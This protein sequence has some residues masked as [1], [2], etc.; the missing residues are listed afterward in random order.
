MKKLLSTTAM[1][2]PISVFA[3]TGTD[4][5]EELVVS[6]TRL[7]ETKSSVL[8][9]VDVVTSEE[10]KIRNLKNL[11]E[12][13]ALLPGVQTSTYGG[14]GQSSS[15]Y[16]RGGN[17]NQVLVLLDGET[18]STGKISNI[19]TNQIPANMIEKVEFIRGHRASVYG[20]N[21]VLGVINIITKP[22]YHTSQR[23]A[24]TY[25]SYATHDFLTQNTIAI[26]DK[27]VIKL[28]GGVGSSKGFNVHPVPGLNDGAEHGYKQHNLQL[29]YSHLFD[30]NLEV[31][32][33]YKYIYNKGDYD[34]SY[35][36]PEIDENEND[37]HLLSGGANYTD[38][39]Y[40][41]DF[42]VMYSHDNDYNYPENT[43]KYGP[44]S[45]A[46]KVKSVNSH[47][48]NEFTVAEPW[49]VGFGVDYD[50]S[51]LDKDSNSYGANFG[52][53]NISL[54]NRAAYLYTKVDNEFMLGELSGRLDDN[55][56][57]GN[58]GTYSIG[59]GGKLPLDSLL[60]VRYG[61]G[62]RAP[63][64]QEL[65]FPYYGNKEL[66]SEKSNNWEVSLTNNN[67]LGNVYVNAFY[68][69]FRNWIGSKPPMYLYENLDKVTIKGLEFGTDLSFLETH[70]FIASASL[71]DTENR[72]TH[73]E[74]DGK[75]KQIYKARYHGSE[76]I[77]GHTIDGF[78]EY[79]FTSK[80]K[81]S[82]VPNQGGFGV[83]NIGVGFSVLNDMVRFGVGADNIFDKKYEYIY[84][85]PTGGAIYSGTVE[86]RNLF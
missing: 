84:G 59:L 53:S 74:L 41:F 24:Y 58:E 61:T 25:S 79:R 19:N 28:A 5:T 72:T 54:I 76:K 13:L 15:F 44:T 42:G 26:T 23:A 45:S 70:H 52:E 31:R 39:F 17:A 43:S 80:R 16:V 69:K 83:V 47:F 38:D 64:M 56:T 12:I 11:S 57:Y 81:F 62:F 78:G 30:N 67:A 10:I 68:N 86:I 4:T 73:K 3:A 60:S 46:F 63:N 82:N 8:G 32:G 2:L 21:A 50:Y 40:S 36:M 55:S 51:R 66:K 35:F 34:N 65:Y 27:D 77:A 85:Y 9:T 49:K 18:Y 20:A 48:T 33:D 7:P 1:L 37:K 14:R 75:A 29:A 71:T 22:E 6:A